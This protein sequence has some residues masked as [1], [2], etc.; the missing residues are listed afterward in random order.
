MEVNE[1]DYIGDVVRR[2]RMSKGMSQLELAEY[3]SLSPKTIHL[4]EGNYHEPR[5]STLYELATALEIDF[6]DLMEQ[7]LQQFYN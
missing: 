4:I 1:L 7:V 5:L 6:R 3:S 2:L